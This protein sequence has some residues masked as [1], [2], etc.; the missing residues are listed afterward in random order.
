MIW[1]ILLTIESLQRLVSLTETPDSIA[2]GRTVSRSYGWR[3]PVRLRR[4]GGNDR[5]VL[6]DHFIFVL[7][8]RNRHK[9]DRTCWADWC[10]ENTSPIVKYAAHPI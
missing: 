10:C 2:E 6:R 9:V 7:S 1:S 3:S 4:R 5:G 8:A